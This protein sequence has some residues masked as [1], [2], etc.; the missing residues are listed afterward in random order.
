MAQEDDV[1]DVLS[2][3]PPRERAIYRSQ[4]LQLE[5]VARRLLE[6][7]PEQKRPRVQFSLVPG[8]SSINAGAASGQIMVTE[9]MLR[10]VRSDDELAMIL[11]HEL[12][13]ITQ[14]HVARGAVNNT[15]LGI[16]SIIANVLVPNSGQLAGT[17]GQLFLNH[18]NQS[19]EREADSIG[20]RYAF[21]AGFDPD[22]GSQ[23][24][25]RMA[26]E[27]PQTATG[28]FFSSH[29]GSIERAEML[30]REAVALGGR[31]KGHHLARED[32][33]RRSE[34]HRDEEP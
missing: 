26:H 30:R 25:E 1:D 10:F 11:G 4:L 31:Q 19:Q 17:V 13:H 9:G 16:G 33:A 18:Y 29:P 6:A 12:A 34:I 3:L 24:M 2:Q 14:G 28:G 8:E 22:A 7:I 27:V 5:R 15:L 23:V 20:L 21:D 32:S